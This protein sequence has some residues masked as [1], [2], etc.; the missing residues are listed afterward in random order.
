MKKLITYIFMDMLKSRIIIAYALFLLMV[1]LVLFSLDDNPGKSLLSILNIAIIVVPLVCMIFSTIHYYNSYEFLELLLAQPMS[2]SAILWCEFAALCAALTLAILTGLGIPSLLYFKGS[3]SLWMIAS[4]SLLSLSCAAIALLISVRTRDKA[5]GIGISLLA[6]F[7]FS[8]IFDGLILLILFSFSDY[9][10]EKFTLALIALNPID[11]S[12]VTIM[13]QL[14]ISALMG[15][16]GA[17]L[18]SFFGTAYGLAATTFVLILWIM[19][20]FSLALK[21]FRKKDM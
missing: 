13:L 16:T 6:W 8:L 21:S 15:Y 12:R 5:R 3:E 4:I 17:L 11:L 20:P 2:R 7:Y 18:K 10:L 1:S 14:D 9:P 19:I